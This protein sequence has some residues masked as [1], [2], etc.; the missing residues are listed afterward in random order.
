LLQ[1][2]DALL[3]RLGPHDHEERDAL[4]EK[5]DAL[6]FQDRVDMERLGVMADLMSLPKTT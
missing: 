6:K 2:Y 4:E 3:K 5:I 1:H